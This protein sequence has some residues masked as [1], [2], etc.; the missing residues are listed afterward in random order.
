[1]KQFETQVLQVAGQNA[2][3]QGLQFALGD[4]IPYSLKFLGHYYILQ[5]AHNCKFPYV[6]NFT[7][8]KKYM[9]ETIIDDNLIFVGII[10]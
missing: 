9:K 10:I 8:W 1:M 7:I 5:L 4:C 2:W 6:L 3:Y